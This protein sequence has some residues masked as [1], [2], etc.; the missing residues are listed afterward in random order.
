MLLEKSELKYLGSLSPGEPTVLMIPGALT[1]PAVFADFDKEIACQ[2]AVIDWSRSA[3]SWDVVL[4]G[5]RVLSLIHELSLGPTVLCGYSAGGIISMSAAIHDEENTICGML[6]S[7]TGACAVGHG[8]YDFPKRIERSWPSIE[9]LDA[10]FARCFARPI[11]VGLKKELTRYA[12]S[13]EKEVALQSTISCRMHDLRG[14]L[15]RIKCPVVIAHGKLDGTRRKEHVQQMV[16]GIY[17]TEVFWLDG[18]HT[19]M[20]EDREN[21]I[22]VLHYLLYKTI[23]YKNSKD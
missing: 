9:L 8:D 21:Y 1:S 19:I 15:H 3:G 7:N 20:Q 6:L 11:K 22:K 18:G 4:I 13:L 17:N 23:F 2:S 5:E 16:E 12:L 10:F 14:D